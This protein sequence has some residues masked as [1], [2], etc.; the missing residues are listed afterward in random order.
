VILPRGLQNRCGLKLRRFTSVVSRAKSFL[1]FSVCSALIVVA[2]LSD[3][4]SQISYSLPTPL[5]PLARA[6]NG[7]VLGG[8]L[9]KVI[10]DINGDGHDDAIYHLFTVGQLF[11][12]GGPSPIVIQCHRR[13]QVL[14]SY[15]SPLLL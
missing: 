4:H 10:V 12:S 9:N 3:A 14:Q 15:T 1:L 2:A 5:F 13:G 11:G 8:P 6:D 7:G